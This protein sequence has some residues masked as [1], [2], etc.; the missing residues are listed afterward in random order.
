M[1]GNNVILADEM[2]LGKTIQTLSFLN[3]LFHD[4]NIDGPFLV[5]VPATTM[6]NWYKECEIWG[7]KMNPIVY[8]GNPEA[9]EHMRNL[10]FYYKNRQVKG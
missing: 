10:E 6:Y 2:G 7:E 1:K 3:F 9:R 8:M 5:V 4:R